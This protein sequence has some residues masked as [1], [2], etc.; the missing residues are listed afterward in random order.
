VVQF[1]KVLNKKVTDPK[2]Y[3]SIFRLQSYTVHTEEQ[4]EKKNLGKMLVY[5]K[6][7]RQYW[8]VFN[9]ICILQKKCLWFF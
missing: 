6:I 1:N 8:L 2:L 5:K 4:R 3:K 7:N 9:M